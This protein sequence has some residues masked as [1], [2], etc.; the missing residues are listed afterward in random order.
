MTSL[1]FDCEADEKL[2][3]AEEAGLIE[4]DSLIGRCCLLL[5][6]FAGAAFGT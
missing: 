5:D 4:R 6:S 1:T 3:D 2:V